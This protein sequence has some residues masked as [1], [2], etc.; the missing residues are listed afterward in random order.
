MV[1]ADQNALARVF[2]TN[3]VASNGVRYDTRVGEREIFGNNAAPA[4]CSEANRM[5]GSE[6][7]REGSQIIL[8]RDCEG[9][10]SWDGASDVKAGRLKLTSTVGF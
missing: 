1:I 7:I 8:T 3:H 2:T 10:N 4:V 9:G 5:H 6:S